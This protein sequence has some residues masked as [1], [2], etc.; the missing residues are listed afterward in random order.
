MIVRP[1]PLIT[2]VGILGTGTSTAESSGCAY[3]LG[4]ADRDLFR[5][6]NCPDADKTFLIHEHRRHTVIVSASLAN[7]LDSFRNK[8]ITQS[9]DFLAEPNCSK[10]IAT[11]VTADQLRCIYVPAATSANPPIPKHHRATVPFAAWRILGAH[12]FPLL[13]IA[14]SSA[15]V[16]Y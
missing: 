14:T 11:C 3:N 15:G 4:P 12:S 16:E 13:H 8:F 1:L 7:R 2:V 10:M 6:L 9:L 5:R